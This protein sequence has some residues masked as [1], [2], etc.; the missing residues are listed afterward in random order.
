MPEGKLPPLSSLSEE[1][2]W[3]EYELAY[4]RCRKQDIRCGCCGQ[5]VMA[6]EHW[7]RMRMAVSPSPDEKRLLSLR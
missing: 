2:Y 1:E 6:C 7:Q 3:R 5:I 4:E